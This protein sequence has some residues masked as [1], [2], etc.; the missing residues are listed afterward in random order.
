MGRRKKA[1][2]SIRN[3]FRSR[4]SIFLG[5]VVCVV[6]FAAFFGV[7]GFIS[8]ADTKNEVTRGVVNSLSEIQAKTALMDDAIDNG[9]SYDRDNVGTE[10]N[11]FLILEIV[12]WLGYAEVG[13][14]IE[15]C[16]PVDYSNVWHGTSAMGFDNIKTGKAVFN[17][18]DD[19]YKGFEANSGSATNHH[20]GLE[21]KLKDND[22]APW[23]E[24]NEK[25]TMTGYYEKVP[26]GQGNFV[27]D[28][29]AENNSERKAENKKIFGNDKE[30]V[31][32]PNFRKAGENESGDFIWVTLDDN[33]W[34]GGPWLVHAKKENKYH[35]DA[36]KKFSFAEG[37]REYTTRTETKYWAMDNRNGDREQAIFVYYNDFLR[38]SL[39][40]RSQ[41]EIKN[42]SIVVKMIE[43][44]ELNANPE[45]I[46][47]ADFIFCHTNDSYGSTRG[48]WND[49]KLVLDGN[50]KLKKDEN[51]NLVGTR[52]V[53]GYGK[54]G[55]STTGENAN[56][57]FKSGLSKDDPKNQNDLSWEAALMLFDKIN[58][59]EF[60]YGDK[61]YK[62][63]DQSYAPLVFDTKIYQ[64]RGNY[65]SAPITYHL[66][67]YEKMALSK[68]KS[69]GTGINN[70]MFKFSV[71]NFL[72]KQENFHALFMTGNNPVVKTNANGE[73]LC[74]I[75]E[76]D[77]A[78]LYWDEHEFLPDNNNSG[79]WS[80][81]KEKYKLSYYGNSFLNFSVN[82][83]NAIWNT[84]FTYDGQAFM[85]YMIG[86]NTIKDNEFSGDA[87][88]W[89][90][91]RE[92]E[93][94]ELST[95]DIIFYLLHYN[96]SGGHNEG[97]RKKI[98]INILDIEP[99][100]SFSTFTETAIYALFP[101]ADYKVTINV[102][103]MTTAEF[104][105]KKMNLSADYDIVYFGNDIEKLNREMEKNVRVGNG[106]SMDIMD[107]RYNDMSSY[108]DS[109][110][111]D[112]R[113]RGKIYSHV[114]D[115]L[116]DKAGNRYRLSGNDIS[117]VKYDEIADYIKSGNTLMFADVLYNDSNSYKYLN[118]RNLDHSSNIHKLLT[119]Y[120]GK[121][122][123]ISLS[124]QLHSNLVS[125]TSKYADVTINKA[126]T[127]YDGT[128][129]DTTLKGNKLTFKFTI[130]GAKEN[131]NYA[132]KLLVDTNGD[133]IV[134]DGENGSEIVDTWDSTAESGA[135]Y[136]N[137]TYE[138]SYTIPDNRG[139]GA[140]A[141]KFVVYNVSNKQIYTQV[142]G[143]SRYAGNSSSTNDGKKTVRILQIVPDGE[144]GQYSDLH[145]NPEKTRKKENENKLF[146]KYADE[147]DDYEF[148]IDT[149][150]L[151]KAAAEQGKYDEN[152]GFIDKINYVNNDA[153]Y[154]GGGNSTERVLFGDAYVPEE[155]Q[156]YSVYLL[157]CGKDFLEENTAQTAASYIAWLENTG[158]SVVFTQ[159]SITDKG[160]PVEAA[161]KLLKD[162]SNLSRFTATSGY[163]KYN[164]KPT[165]S[166]G[167][168]DA[169]KA[170]YDASKYKSL[171]YTYMAAV[172]AGSKDNTY[173]PFD[174]KI[175]KKSDGSGMSYG[176]GYQS[177]KVATCTNVGTITM[178]PYNICNSITRDDAYP[179][180]KIAGTTAQTYQLNMDN[181]A[182]DVW[183]CLG[184]KDDTTYG[185]SPNDAT[186]NYYL[187]NVD[188]VFYD[189]IEL[190]NENVADLEM[191]LFINTLVGAYEASYAEPRVEVDRAVKLKDGSGK[192]KVDD[193]EIKVTEEGYDS[194][195]RTRRYSM[196]VSEVTGSVIKDIEYKEYI[197]NSQSLA[198]S[199]VTP[200]PSTPKP[201]QNPEA[202]ETPE[203]SKTP[204]PPPKKP[205]TVIYDSQVQSNGVSVELG[206]Y[207]DW[208]KG[209]SNDAVMEITYTCLG[210]VDKSQT[211]F[212]F[213]GGYDNW[214]Y[215]LSILA[216]SDNGATKT[217][218]KQK[219]RINIGA[220]KDS[221][222]NKVKREDD[223][224]WLY[225]Q[226]MHWQSVLL[227]VKLYASEY[228]ITDDD[229][230]GGDDVPDNSSGNQ[231]NEIDVTDEKYMDASD[232]HKIYF[233]PF[234]GNLV[235]GKIRY[236]SA[237]YVKDEQ[238]TEPDAEM[239]ISKIYREYTDKDGNK[240]VK[241]LSSESG[242]YL[243]EDGG[244]LRDS[245]RYFILYNETYV[246]QWE[247]IRFDIQN[248]KVAAKT[249]LNITNTPV[250]PQQNDDVYIFNLD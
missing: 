203:A 149:I 179:K 187:Y 101:P 122:N 114:G 108:S 137:G 156:D 140:I 208:M 231:S 138:V 97:G 18:F 15:G 117:S 235:G 178:Y 112:I 194:A 98:K 168:D 143:V 107:T 5:V 161:Q 83:N 42:K 53:I 196:T 26:A 171:E 2:F 193:K 215:G 44:D 30:N 120:K 34:D 190:K 233:T 41:E 234:D 116:T 186:N 176:T 189:G 103:T 78:K 191:Q 29:D 60:N 230:V 28:G 70:N 229:T 180:L 243:E 210:E 239:P 50:G 154:S 92:D 14:M 9:K 82:G 6:A 91:D 73:G 86:G 212:Q 102:D 121:N 130:K 7:H 63:D 184:G 99:C 47:Y 146:K 90:K 55:E 167:T 200:A 238:N 13:Y 250:T 214:V 84:T 105:G 245:V 201:T 242:I 1:G 181:P 135:V 158:K 162:S 226:S 247:Y 96:K 202:T 49:S 148:I 160:S 51:G 204:T 100:N 159:D 17:C 3:I 124:N 224:Q 48:L 118:P 236:F 72:M 75:Q 106:T 205:A 175:W 54:N 19:E 216:S 81:F 237:K 24:R 131:E 38:T 76:S 151:K 40:W 141:W 199:K 43:P 126:P 213:V 111:G 115:L 223:I 209:L 249:F 32:R 77:T 177:A 157:S 46:K 225:L 185:I 27:C 35:K 164:D 206:K 104:N 241:M 109:S 232:T 36:G 89:Y 31:Y 66:L 123:V 197:K 95:A 61:K 172:N 16:E 142:S 165:Y 69:S 52:K 221:F 153:N 182:T 45:W 129:E 39:L 110:R 62:F 128:K 198:G 85:T 67:D 20:N 127:I 33:S 136:S 23:L 119:E 188:N 228:D 87:F 22:K 88:D 150:P 4:G 11:P 80:A 145:N 10:E 163:N 147:L 8:K 174:G 113:L 133:G 65:A 25:K 74:S 64:N 58:G 169:K 207:A 244:F 192:N 134:T 152:M 155:F 79:D 220:L 71:M 12:P 59:F 57:G 37:D 166:E 94:G 21:Q 217:T 211:L 68:S 173:L 240:H 227:N 170:K 219:V 246:N 56:Y 132:V 144:I 195:S 222:S 218:E 93:R 125:D 248:K 183:F 139:N